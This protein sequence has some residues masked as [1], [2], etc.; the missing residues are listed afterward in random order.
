MLTAFGVLAKLRGLRGTALDVFGHTEER[1]MERALIDDY[2]RTVS[3]LLDGLDSGNIALAAEIA[4][5]PEH[6]RGYGHVKHAHF[7]K[8]KAREA[9]LLREW[10]NPLRIVQAA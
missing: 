4:S 5:I 6:I 3:G 8:A 2:E 9:E 10:A 7:E 1:R